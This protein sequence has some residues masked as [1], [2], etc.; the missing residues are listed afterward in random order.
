MNDQHTSVPRIRAIGLILGAYLFGTAGGLFLHPY[1]PYPA[2]V[3]FGVLGLG[4][5]VSLVVVLASARR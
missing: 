1:L 3:G 2:L 4:G 5:L